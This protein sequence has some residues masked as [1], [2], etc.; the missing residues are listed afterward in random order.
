VEK[1]LV[2]Y[3]LGPSNQR[4]ALGGLGGAAGPH[5]CLIERPSMKEVLDF[6]AETLAP[7]VWGLE[8][9]PIE[10]EIGTP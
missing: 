2:I 6:L 4:E 3:H 10:K 1:F 5:H 8:I 9:H 7:D